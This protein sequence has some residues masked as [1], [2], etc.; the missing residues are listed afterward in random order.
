M[1]NIYEIFTPNAVASYWTEAGLN[2]VPYLGKGLFPNKK[3]FGLDLAWIK[4]HKNVPVSLMPTTF[5][6]KATF[7]DREGFKFTET[8]MPFFREGYKIKEKDRQELLKYQEANNPYLNDAIARIYDDTGDLIAGAD[9][10]SE[11]MRMQLL[12]PEEGNI[13]INIAANGVNYS[14]NYDADGSWKATNY[15]ALTGTDA[16]DNAGN[17]N[18]IEALVSIQRNARATDGTELR[19]CVMNSVTFAPL[20]KNAALIKFASNDL[21]IAS[22]DM[23]L[24]AIRS[25]YGLDIVLYDKTYRDEDKVVHKYVPD[26]YV[27]FLPEGILGSTW[28]GTTPEEADLMASDKAE[29]VLYDGV[30]AVAREIQEHPVNVNI[31]AS[32][33]VLPSFEA[34]DSFYSI[35]VFEN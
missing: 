8:E 32:E 1:A 10:V 6:A 33:I 25:V 27:A 35:K 24:N 7:R 30:V 11:R 12:F 5:D 16:W 20:A 4:G 34:M 26:G 14:Y 28:Y 29:V 17:V 22:D 31:F 18:P 3:K 2:K 21:G 15:I 9:V 13:G 19:R 23:I